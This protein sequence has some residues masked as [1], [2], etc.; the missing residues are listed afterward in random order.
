MRARLAEVEQ[1]MSD[2]GRV[3]VLGSLLSAADVRAAWDALDGDRRRAVIATLM[4]RVTVLP[5]GR[6]ARTFD[7]STV[8][9]DWRE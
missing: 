6:G 8:R 7:P 9:I 2:A 1:A 4:Q 5:P 3:N